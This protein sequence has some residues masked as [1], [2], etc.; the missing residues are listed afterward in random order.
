MRDGFIFYESF[1]DAMR[2]LPAETQLVLYNA[3]ADYALYDEVPDFGNDGIAKGFFA[4]MRPQIDA[5][6]RRRDVGARGGRPAKSSTQEPNENQIETDEEPIDNQSI[7]EAKPN[8]NLG[9][10][11]AEP[12]A[13]EKAKENAKDKAKEKECC[14]GGPRC[15]TKPTVDEIRVYCQERGNT[16]EAQRFFDF[17]E[18]KG[19]RV[20]NQPMKDWQAAVRTWEGRDSVKPRDQTGGFVKKDARPSIE[21]HDFTDDDLAHLLVDLDVEPQERVETG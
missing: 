19:W 8:D 7:T 4:L 9:I 10:T 20:G 18:A 11:K 16:V 14:A 13:K 1:R 5:N 2:D 3:I 21:Q 17:Y 15:F 6:N 12:N